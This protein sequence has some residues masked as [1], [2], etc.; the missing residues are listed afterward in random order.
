M[1][2]VQGIN[3]IKAYLQR[4]KQ[5][6]VQ[7]L[8]V[9]LVKAGRFLQGQSM[10]VVPVDYGFLKASAYTAVFGA[11]TPDVEVN[12]GYNAAYALFVHENTQAVHGRNFNT[13]HAK[14]LAAAKKKKRKHQSVKGPF[15][16][17]RGPNQQ[18]KFLEAPF[19]IH[20]QTLLDIVKQELK[21]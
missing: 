21:K 16:H 19:R 10:N 11:N 3:N 5:Q 14:E 1:A 12:V 8:T 18:A 2:V 13:K 15:R 7:K 9:G 6:E 4:R 17:D 20:K